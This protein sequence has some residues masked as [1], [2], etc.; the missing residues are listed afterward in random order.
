M[1]CIDSDW[2]ASPIY[3][4]YNST[5]TDLA[6][7]TREEKSIA[8]K[9]LGV[10]SQNPELLPREFVNRGVYITMQ[11]QTRM[12]FLTNKEHQ[13]VILT[14]DKEPVFEIVDMCPHCGQ[15]NPGRK[16]RMEYKYV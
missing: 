1:L 11:K 2:M 15:I 12:V 16:Y 10:L 14:D 5:T 9:L 6:E 8:A 3:S 4:W 7:F 13:V